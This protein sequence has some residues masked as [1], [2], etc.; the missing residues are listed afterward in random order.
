MN[1]FLRTLRINLEKPRRDSGGRE[2]HPSFLSRCSALC[3][4]DTPL[5]E[6]IKNVNLKQEEALLIAL[7]HLYLH[8]Y[9]F[10]YLCVQVHTR[11]CM[12][13][14]IGGQLARVESSFLPRGFLGIKLQSQG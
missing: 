12:H 13:V 4:K 3:C 1:K 5:L 7:L 11:L 9:L 8:L 10:I 14:E 2:G 6:E